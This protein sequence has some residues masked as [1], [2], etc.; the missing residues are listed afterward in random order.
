MA[1]SNVPNKHDNKNRIKVITINDP[2][3][4]IPE[5]NGY[6]DSNIE[7]DYNNEI[8]N[9]N[10]DDGF[11]NDEIVQNENNNL[12]LNTKN[13]NNNFIYNKSNSLVAPIV[14]SQR[15]TVNDTNRSKDSNSNSNIY[16]YDKMSNNDIVPM[17]TVKDYEELSPKQA[18]LCDKR[19]FFI[20]LWDNLK[21]EHT[22]INLIFKIS[23]VVPLW[24]R[25]IGFCFEISLMICLNSIF[26]TD[27]LIDNRLY[28]EK[29]ER[30]S[31]FNI[32]FLFNNL[33]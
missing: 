23:I 27:D 6:L 2:N 13:V 5:E 18:R 1:D 3:E 14:Y 26:F 21:E 17:K 11:I 32:E 9:F 30:V 16:Q 28:V 22:L 12:H 15:K 29:E 24:K 25:V 31:I 8:L 19:P 20:L 33:F 10:R 4:A 7:S